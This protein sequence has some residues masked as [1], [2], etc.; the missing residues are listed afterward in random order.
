MGLRQICHSGRIISEVGKRNML[1]GGA[2]RLNTDHEN[3]GA[4]GWI[5]WKTGYPMLTVTNTQCTWVR[6]GT[7][8]SCLAFGESQ[9]EAATTGNGAFNMPCKTPPYRRFKK[10]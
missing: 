6:I 4:V 1:A 5:K 3:G 10:S 8:L 2:S 9:A 7:R